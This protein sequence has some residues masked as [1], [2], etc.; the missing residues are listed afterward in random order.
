MLYLYNQG[1][2][3]VN[4]EVKLNRLG[5][6]RYCRL[7]DHTIIDALGVGLRYRS[8]DKTPLEDED[9]DYFHLETPRK[10]IVGVNIL[11]GIEVKV[12]RSD[13]R[14]GFICN[15][16]NYNY[17]LTPMSLLSPHEVPDGVGLIE[18][19]KYKFKCKMLEDERNE[20]PFKIKGLRVIKRPKHRRVPRFQIDNAVARIT[21]RRK[22]E[23]LRKV[24]NDVKDEVDEIIQNF[25]LY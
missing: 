20:R 15:G 1:C 5:L 17:I 7:D 18:F 19:N 13:Y 23:D 14:N 11:R 25:K 2:Y 24:F 16:C 3:L 4:T 10:Y 22:M 6:E 21:N 9:A 12:S 8:L